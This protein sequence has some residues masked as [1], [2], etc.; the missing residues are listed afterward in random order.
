[1]LW[2]LASANRYGGAGHTKTPTYRDCFLTKQEIELAPSPNS[3]PT[4]DNFLL[5]YDLA[6]P[7]FLLYSENYK[8]S[9]PQKTTY[10]GT[11]SGNLI[12]TRLATFSSS[13]IPHI[14]IR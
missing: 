3:V 11:L 4:Q 8:D 5:L 1:M 14:Y 6:L 9:T 13:R 7:P 10:A 12:Y 2:P